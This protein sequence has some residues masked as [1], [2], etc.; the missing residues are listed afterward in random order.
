MGLDKTTELIN[1]IVE[2]MIRLNDSLKKDEEKVEQ[3]YRERKNMKH[4]SIIWIIFTSVLWLLFLP[5]NY[6]LNL[7]KLGIYVFLLILFTFISYT[8]VKLYLKNSNIERYM[9]YARKNYTLSLSNDIQLLTDRIE[10]TTKERDVLQEKRE[11]YLQKQWGHIPESE[12]LET[13]ESDYNL[14]LEPISKMTEMDNVNQKSEEVIQESD[15]FD[16]Y[17]TGDL[18]SDYS[19]ELSYIKTCQTIDQLEYEYTTVS[20]SLKKTSDRLEKIRMKL[21]ST[22]MLGLFLIFL[23]YLLLYSSIFAFMI[24]L[25]P[26]VLLTMV[27]PYIFYLFKIIRAY[28]MNLEFT[29]EY[30]RKI[31]YP[32]IQLEKEKYHEQ[33]LYLEKEI[34]RLKGF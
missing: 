15:H 17:K 9:E 14:L 11:F 1:A 18:R 20:Y 34:M 3:L 6:N 16:Q 2:K 31:G 30:A 4:F 27:L 28:I 13:M 25:L 26:I 19:E 33:L 22:V 7:M 8:K 29:K 32:S 24:V 10:R 12:Y 21:I 5:L 23:L